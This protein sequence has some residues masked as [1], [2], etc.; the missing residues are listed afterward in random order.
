MALA[1]PIANQ[2]GAPQPIT[3]AA[4]VLTGIIGANFVQLLLNAFQFR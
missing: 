4:V 3:A 1:L 2:L